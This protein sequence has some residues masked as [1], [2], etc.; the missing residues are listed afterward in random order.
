MSTPGKQVAQGMKGFKPNTTTPTPGRQTALDM[1]GFKPKA[2]PTQPVPG[3]SVSK[4]GASVSKGP[5]VAKRV[6]GGI[7]VARRLGGGI[8]QNGHPAG[9]GPIVPIMAV[10]FIIV[11]VA[12]IRGAAQINVKRA[13]FGG[14][15]ATF[16]LMA[17]YKLNASLGTAFAA[18]VLVQV[19]L[20]Y[21]LTALQGLT[22]TGS[23]ASSKL[24]TTTL[25]SS[26]GTPYSS[27]GLAPLAPNAK[28]EN[29]IGQSPQLVALPGGG[30][31]ELPATTDVS[32]WLKQHGYS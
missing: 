29:N 3:E 23:Y 5:G 17:L 18:L 32:A 7:N 12:K 11:A 24:G 10:V 26:D 21:G 25:F 30:Q 13:V 31:V 15:L 28:P 2:E 9:T 22:Q 4:G 20:E 8:V 14:F 27:N 16:L 6:G 19:L 1:K